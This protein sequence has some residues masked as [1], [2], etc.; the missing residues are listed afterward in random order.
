LQYASDCAT[1]TRMTEPFGQHWFEA[2]FS[3]GR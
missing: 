1:S 2:D 3:H